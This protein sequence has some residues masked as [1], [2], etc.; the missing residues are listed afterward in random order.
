MY[1]YDYICYKCLQ[2]HMERKW[3]IV[4]LGLHCSLPFFRECLKKCCVCSVCYK[5]TQKGLPLGTIVASP[6]DVS[7]E[8][9]ATSSFGS[10]T[11]TRDPVGARDLR[12]GIGLLVENGPRFVASCATLPSYAKP[13][14]QG[15]KCWASGARVRWPSTQP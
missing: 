4:D 1:T 11:R 8:R 6:C 13:G 9:G 15:L 12:P 14:P 7:P 2:E 3:K 5:V 10:E